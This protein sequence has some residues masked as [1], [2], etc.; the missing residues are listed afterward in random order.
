MPSILL[1][2]M[3]STNTIFPEKVVQNQMN[4]SFYEGLQR[5]VKLLICQGVVIKI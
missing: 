4:I 1:W 5:P 3:G 2:V